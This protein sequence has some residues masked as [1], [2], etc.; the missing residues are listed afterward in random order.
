MSEDMQRDA[1]EYA[2]Q[3]L[4]KFNSNYDIAKYIKLVTSQTIHS[5]T[6]KSSVDLTGRVYTGS[7]ITIEV[8]FASEHAI[9]KTCN[10]HSPLICSSLLC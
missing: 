6:V 8:Q 5:C 7:Q 3:A 4:K 9:V 1:V 2:T 10:C